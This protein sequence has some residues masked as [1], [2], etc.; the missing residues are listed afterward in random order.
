MI[1]WFALLLSGLLVV[2]PF[3]TRAHHTRDH[4]MLAEDTQKVIAA[5]QQGADV[6]LIWLVWFAVLLMM[7]LGLVRWWRQRSHK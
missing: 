7:I 6:T 3:T 4:M 5:T 2:L 1:R